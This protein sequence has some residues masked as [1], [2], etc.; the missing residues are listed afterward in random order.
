MLVHFRDQLN[1][2]RTEPY[3]IYGGPPRLLGIFPLPH[4]RESLFLWAGILFIISLAAVTFNFAM[5]PALALA[6]VSFVIYFP[7]ILPL[8]YIQRKVNLIPIVL[9]AALLAPSDLLPL[10]RLAVA[11]VY[12]SA[13]VEKLRTAGFRW[14]DGESLRAY[15]VEN[16][17][18]HS[19]PQT[20]FLIERRGLCTLLST[21]VLFWEL[22]FWLAILSPSVALIYAMFGLLFHSGTSLTMRIHYWIYF[23]PAYFAF[24]VPFLTR[25]AS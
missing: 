15:L 13:G 19:R 1:F 5:Q 7:P 14:A 2:F 25:H 24:F 3:Q 18:F 6:V 17:L 9:A 10:T 11:L 12:L 20:V 8:A 16:Y 21:V 4:V 22:S 23:G